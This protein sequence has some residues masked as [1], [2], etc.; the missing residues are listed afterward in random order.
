MLKIG[1]LVLHS[2]YILAPMAGV[3]DLP[4]RLINRDFGCELAFVEMVNVRALSYKNNKTKR[5]LTRVDTDNPLGVQLLGSE[6]RYILRALEI[7]NGYNFDL[8]DLNAACPMKKIVRR[9]EGAALLKDPAKLQSLLKLIIDNCNVP[10]TVKIRIGWDKKTINA[11]DVARR[12][13]DVGVKALFIHG[14]TKAQVYHDN[15][16]YDVIAQVKKA[17]KIPVIASGDVFSGELAKKMFDETGADAVII[18]RGA[19]GYP[20]IF[21]EVKEYSKSGI[22][23]PRPSREEIAKVI[24]KHLDLVVDFYGEETA[25][26][27]F[28]K[29]FI[30]YTH[31]FSNARPLRKTA[32]LALTKQ[33]M[34]VL[35]DKFIQ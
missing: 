25:I 20:W 31:G 28:R 34:L 35:I 29:F 1:N 19:L 4:F 30:W 22:A 24:R 16:D 10:V 32:S 12:V 7:I 26:L 14:R 8:I 11:I 18:A 13:E 2:P 3:S 15:V 21:Q 23:L 33:E 17:V 6:P 27:I 9:E 5:L